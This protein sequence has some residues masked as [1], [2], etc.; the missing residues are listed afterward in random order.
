VTTRKRY[1]TVVLVFTV[2]TVG[3]AF[4]DWAGYTAAL[5]TL[6]FITRREWIK[7]WPPD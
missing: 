4:S 6:I 1:L 7:K 5:L 3:S 2:A